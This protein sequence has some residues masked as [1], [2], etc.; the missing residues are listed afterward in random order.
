MDYDDNLARISQR[1]FLTMEQTRKWNI[2]S[3]FQTH[4]LRMF[5]AAIQRNTDFLKFDIQINWHELFTKMQK[6]I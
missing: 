3:M 4:E 5:A 1:I 6:I 2:K